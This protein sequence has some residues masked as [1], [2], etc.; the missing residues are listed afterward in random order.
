MRIYH[1]LAICH[2]LTLTCS[3]TTL[4][5]V[6]GSK[7]KVYNMKTK[8]IICLS[9]PQSRLWCARVISV[10]SYRTKHDGPQG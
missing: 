6:D 8:E 3:Y 4:T 9:L 1:F 10:R 7:L 5:N 2:E